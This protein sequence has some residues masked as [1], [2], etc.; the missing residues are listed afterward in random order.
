MP[1]PSPPRWLRRCNRLPPEMKSR[2]KL[3]FIGHIEEPRFREALLQ[4][5]DDSGI[6]GLRAAAR[7]SGRNERNR[8]CAADHPRPLNVAAKFYD[9]IGGGKPILATVHPEGETRRLLEELRA[10]W[11]AAI[12]MWKASAGS[13]SSCGPRQFSAHEFQPDTE[14]IAQ[15]ERKVLA[16]RYAA[17]LHSIA[18]R[19]R[20]S[21]SQ[22]AAAILERDVAMLKIA[23]V[24]R[25]FPSSARA[26]AGP[27]GLSDA[28]RACPRGRC[29]GLLSQRRVSVFAQATEP[30]LRQ[31]RRFL[32]PAG[33]EG[34]LLRLSCPAPGFP[35]VERLD[36]RP[37]AAASRSR[38]CSRSHLQLFFS[39]RM[40][41][42][43][44][45]SARPSL[46][47][48]S[49]RALGPISTGSAIPFRPCTR[50]RFCAKP[51]F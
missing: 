46:F 16:Q 29:A 24:T 44:S 11:W 2:F 4:L 38:L 5:G 36:G 21:G 14:K 1:Q 42:P 50:A 43:L 34:E 3:R 48:S 26:L 10:G 37:C 25:Y 47:R 19:Q 28:A 27:V 30:E 51:I 6:E 39:T 17:L 18:G 31:A 35:A 33:C 41:M 13:S 12:A 9:Y 32:Q 49:P 22:A 40:G 7:S 45:K 20:E 8:L 23:V 15:Y